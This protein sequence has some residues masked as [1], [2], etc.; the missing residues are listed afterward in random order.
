MS[1]RSQRRAAATTARVPFVV[2]RISVERY[3]LHVLARRVAEVEAGDANGVPLAAEDALAERVTQRAGLLDLGGAEHPLVPGGERLADRG[4][5]PDDVDDDPG[6]GRSGLVRS[7]HDVH[8]HAGTLTRRG[9]AAPLLQAS[10]PRDVRLVL[11]VRPRDLPRLHD[12][13]AR[14]ASAARTTRRAG[15]KAAAPRASRAHDLAH[16]LRV[17]AVRHVHADRDQRR[18]VPPASS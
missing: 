17:R 5:R 4:R 8:A 12:R 15:G 3:G 9:R 7:E 16:A 10:R 2:E 11:G 18:R 14:S 6:R 1:T 13:T